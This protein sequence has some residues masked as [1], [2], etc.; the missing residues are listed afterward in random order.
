MREIEVKQL[1]CD[2]MAVAGLALVGDYLK[3]IVP[4][5]KRVNK[6]LPVR[7]GW[8]TA[9]SCAAAW[10]CWCRRERLDAIE[11]YRLDSCTPDDHPMTTPPEDT[12]AMSP[13]LLQGLRALR[14]GEGW[15]THHPGRQERRSPRYTTRL[16]E[17]PLVIA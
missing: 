15:D 1:D 17:I 4:V 2:L 16:D 9:I 13:E 11:N 3:T 7:S 8:P 6:A 10:G 14:V 12:A 5:L